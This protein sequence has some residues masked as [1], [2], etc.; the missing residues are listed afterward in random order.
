[1]IRF[2][3][4]INQ[5][6]FNPRLERTST[7]R[8]TVGEVWINEAYV[9]SIRE[10]VGYNSLLK[11]GLLPPNLNDQHRFTTVTTHNGTLSESH[12]VVGSPE[13]VAARLHKD[14]TQLLK[15]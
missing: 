13:V 6:D 2:V 11:E 12:V 5:T 7:P 10:A 4:I 14:R 3:E 8:F 15:G 9:V 1:M